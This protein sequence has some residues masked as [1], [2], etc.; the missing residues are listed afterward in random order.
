MSVRKIQLK[1]WMTAIEAG[2]PVTQDYSGGPSPG[3]AAAE[4]GISRQAVHDAIKR[5]DLEALAVYRGRR[6]SHYTISVSSLRRYKAYIDT[7][8]AAEMLRTRR[9]S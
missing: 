8:A 1:D 9:G 7:K 5:G 3:G 6:L 4:L 2:D